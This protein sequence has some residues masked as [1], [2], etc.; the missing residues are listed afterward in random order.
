[1]KWA[2]Y[3]LLAA[4]AAP[5]QQALYL[6]LSGE[7]RQHHGDQPAYAQPGFDDRGWTV[8]RLPWQQQSEATLFWLRRTVDLPEWA[9]RMPLA[10]TLGPVSPVYEVYVNGVRIA[11]TGPFFDDGAVYPARSRTHPIPPAAGAGRSRLTVAVRARSYDFATRTLT[12]FRGG[13]YALTDVRSA[14]GHRDFDV[15]TRQRILFAP[16][17]ALSI[18]LFSFALL[19]VLLWLTNR[20]RTEPVWLGLLV[21]LRAE[22]DWRNFH[23]LA[24]DAGR[25]FRSPLSQALGEASLIELALASA[26]LRPGWWRV[27]IW[28]AAAGIVWLPDVQWRVG[29]RGMDVAA[30]LLVAWGWWRNGGVRQRPIPHL[31][32]GTLVLL[33][34]ARMNS[35][36]L[37]LFPVFVNVAGYLWSAQSSMTVAFAAIL[38]I[39][40]VLSL[41]A[42]RRERQRLASELEAARGVQQLLITGSKALPSG[43]AIDSVYEPAQEVGGDFYQV[44]TASDGALLVVVGDVS[45]KGLQAALVVSMMTGV[46]RSHRD[47]APAALLSAMNSVLGEGSGGFVTAIACRFAVDGELTMA[48]AGHLNPY[49]AGVETA[50]EPGLPLGVAPGLEYPETVFRLQPG[51]M[52]TFVTD[53]IVEAANPQGELFG[54][55]RTCEISGKSAAEIA[56]AAKA[57][58]QNDDITVVTVRRNAV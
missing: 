46:I 23:F 32:A 16:A 11:Q 27:L 17:M 1:M 12:I 4:S 54:F 55:D 2:F 20:V 6:D 25:H 34:L 8:V 7:W 49:R 24:E 38:T 40:L 56:A 52:I 5:G 31:I 19:L 58:G 22:F 21:A 10:L 41:G 28:G 26:G 13:T 39:L 57:C 15:L 33:T 47:L 50:T 45:G 42:D 18:L 48:N 29:T 3:L 36:G 43:Y 30:I 53:G 44:F 37:G 14:R 51:E 9:A 35:G